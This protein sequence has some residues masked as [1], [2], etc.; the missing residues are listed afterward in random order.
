MA[1]DFTSRLIIELHTEW[2]CVELHT[3]W[4]CIELRTEWER[5]TALSSL[6]GYVLLLKRGRDLGEGKR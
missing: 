6:M 5:V 1:V 2:E 4:E 3:E